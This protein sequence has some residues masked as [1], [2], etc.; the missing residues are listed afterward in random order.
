MD[1]F[2]CLYSCVRVTIKVARKPIVSG[3]T[4]RIEKLTFRKDQIRGTVKLDKELNPFDPFF[5]E[6][7]NVHLFRTFLMAV[8]DNRFVV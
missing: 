4:T 8:G 6:Q 1:E 3:C 7:V 2:V 5:A